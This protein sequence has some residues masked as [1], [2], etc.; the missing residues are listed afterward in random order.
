MAKKQILKLLIKIF[1]GFHANQLPNKLHRPNTFFPIKSSIRKN[2]PKSSPHS[3]YLYI[4]RNWKIYSA[5]EKT[6]EITSIYAEL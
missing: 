5:I 2:S 3:N 1:K 4:D 6:T